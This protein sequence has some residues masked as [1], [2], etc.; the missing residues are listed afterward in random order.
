MSVYGGNHP[1][2]REDD[3]FTHQLSYEKY[4]SSEGSK[5]R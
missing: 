4:D 3:E 5:H 2:F 1:I